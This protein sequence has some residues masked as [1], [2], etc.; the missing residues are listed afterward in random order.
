MKAARGV[1]PVVKVDLQGAA[2]LQRIAVVA[3]GR[4]HT[5]RA[6]ADTR[7]LL[8]RLLRP[9]WRADEGRLDLAEVIPSLAGGESIDLETKQNRGSERAHG[10]PPTV[11]H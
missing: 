6:A 2:P 9:G 5:A 4:E 10:R 1:M 3:Q 11:I 8:T 7:I